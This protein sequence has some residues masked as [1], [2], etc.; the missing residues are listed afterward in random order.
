MKV[1]SE[2]SQH[3]SKDTFLGESPNISIY[4]TFLVCQTETSDTL[5]LRCVTLAP[6]ERME[7]GKVEVIETE[8]RGSECNSSI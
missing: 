1:I 2:T 5:Y 7:G 3:R 4:R 6:K 8:S